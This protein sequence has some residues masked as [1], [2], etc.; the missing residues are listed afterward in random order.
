MMV[1]LGRELRR[2]EVDAVVVWLRW[3]TGEGDKIA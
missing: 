1:A 3:C 2:R